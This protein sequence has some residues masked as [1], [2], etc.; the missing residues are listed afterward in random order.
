MPHPEGYRTTADLVRGILALGPFDVSVSAYPEK[1]PQSATI[2]ADID[3]LE[4]KVDAGATR[5][6]TQFFFDNDLY[7]RY[8]D[9]VRARGITIPVIPGI[10]PVQNFQ[11]TASFAAKTGASIPAWLAKRFDGLD[12]DAATRRLVAATVAAEQVFDLL[13]QGVSDFHF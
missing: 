11:Q 12:D 5:A 6:I 3:V 13:D 10:L 2:E 4:A 9:R 8:L 1:H 7:F